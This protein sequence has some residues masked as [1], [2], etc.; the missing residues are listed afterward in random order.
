LLERRAGLGG[1]DVGAILGLSPYRTPVDVY[2]EKT[3][4][5]EPQDE[6]LQ[7]RFGTYAEEFVAREYTAKTGNY[8]QRYTPMLRHPVA[9]LIGHV[10]RLVIP[11][12]AKIAAHQGRIRTDL[13]LEAKTASAFAAYKPDEWGE[14]GTDAVPMAYLVQCAT[15]MALSGCSAWDLAVLFGNQEVRVYNLRRDLELEAEIIA[16]ASEWWDR[17]VIADRAPDPVCDSDI[18]RLYPSDNGSAIEANPKTLELIARAVE[19]KA[20][21]A[22]LEAELDGDK[23]AGTIGVIGSLKAYM[24]DASRLVLGEHELVT[25]KQAKQT[26]RL[27][28][29]AFRSALPE[30][31]SQYLK[32]GEGSRRFIIKEQ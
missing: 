21:I 6:T 3:G 26:M 24:G 25:W 31:Y 5:A 23:K 14:E 7:M 8:V 16:R 1:S 22:A 30:I 17:H 4:R 12:G 29:A 32:A 13:G 10:D 28:T 27:D 15:Y 9:P 18:K 2:L 20:Q 19:L 11:P